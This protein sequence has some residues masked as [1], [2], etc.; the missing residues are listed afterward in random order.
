[1]DL[2]EYYNSQRKKLV[3]PEYGRHVQEMVDHLLTVESRDERNRMAKGL[4]NVMSN[5]TPG[6]RENA[7]FKLKLWNHLAQMAGYK[8]DIDYPCEITKEEELLKR[9]HALPYPTNNIR[10]KH[11]G[12][13]AKAFVKKFIDMPDSESKTVL[14]EMLANHMKKLYLVWNKEAVS[15]EQIFADI[16]EMAGDTPLI[17][18]HI[19]L[20]E[21]R[22]ILYRNQKPKPVK[23]FKRTNRKQR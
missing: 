13:I 2:N 23:P 17:N 21:T 4:I 10:H 18:G 15:D 7:E 3:L 16:N 12:G 1:M 19:R 9:P 20:N 5:F 6:M 14:I 22:D 8:L 11:Y